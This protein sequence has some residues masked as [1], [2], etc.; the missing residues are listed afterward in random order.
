VTGSEHYNLVELGE[1][2]QT[3]LSIRS[4]IN[5]NGDRIAFRKRQL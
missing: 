5:P 2:S 3:F 4:N 1:L